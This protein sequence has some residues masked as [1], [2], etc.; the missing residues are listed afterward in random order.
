MVAFHDVHD[1]V[2]LEETMV[3]NE[4]AEVFV[5]QKGAATVGAGFDSRRSTTAK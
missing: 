5:C 4:L 3:S 1:Q 2:F